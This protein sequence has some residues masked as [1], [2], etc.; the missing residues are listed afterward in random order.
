MAEEKVVLVHKDL[1][2]AVNICAPEAVE[3]WEA[4]GWVRQTA[5]KKGSK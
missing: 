4:V 5:T 1:P 3:G 2:D